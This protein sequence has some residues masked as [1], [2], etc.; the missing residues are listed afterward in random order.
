MGA[1]IKGGTIMAKNVKRALEYKAKHKYFVC[2]TKDE[3]ETA[4]QELLELKCDVPV[5]AGIGNQIIG[6][7]A[8]RIKAKIITKEAN[9]VT[10][11]DGSLILEEVRGRPDTHC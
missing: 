8:P 2:G 9:G 5:P 7:N 10:T 4:N 3:T 11:P 1:R 6:E